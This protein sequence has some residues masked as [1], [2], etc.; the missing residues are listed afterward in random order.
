MNQAIQR[1]SEDE[2]ETLQ[3]KFAQAAQRAE[4]ED[5]TLQGKFEQPLQRE[6]DEE[7]VQGKFEAPVQ[8]K[9]ETGMPDNLK[10]GIEELSGFS[11]DDRPPCRPLPTRKAPTSTWHRAKNS[12]CRTRHGTWR[13]RWRG[14]WSRP[15]R[16]AGCP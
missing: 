14:V 9:N 12:T 7:A 15:P 3:G 10:N 16:W 4:D 13:N 11:M 6:E 1:A 2:D 8:K 5:D